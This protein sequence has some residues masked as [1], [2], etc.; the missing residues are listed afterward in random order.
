[1]LLYFE[2]SSSTMNS[3]KSLKLLPAMATIDTIMN[4]LSPNPRKSEPPPPPP[5]QP[6][7]P[8]IVLMGLAIV[9]MV[10]LMF[11][12]HKDWMLHLQAKRTWFMISLSVLMIS[13]SGTMFSLLR[14]VGP[15]YIGPHGVFLVHPSSKQQFFLEGWFMGGCYSIGS[16]ALLTLCRIVPTFESSE[17]RRVGSVCCVF[18]M[19]L[20][21]QLVYWSF[22]VKNRWY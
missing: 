18:V 3:P 21:L 16:A 10:M 20:A 7:I 9:P 19:G 8:W 4:F 11:L 6:L 17:T 5:P 14:A 22:C 1:M 12:K 13:M 2:S 15:F